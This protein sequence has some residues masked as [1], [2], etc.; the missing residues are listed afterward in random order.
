MR[1]DLSFSNVDFES[2]ITTKVNK[3]HESVDRVLPLDIDH[4]EKE[5]NE[6]SLSCLGSASK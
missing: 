6:Q 1:S 5:D 2:Q 3:N 4:T